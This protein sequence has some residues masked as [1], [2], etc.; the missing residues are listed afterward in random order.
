MWAFL[1]AL[2]HCH[3]VPIVVDKG[4]KQPLPTL[5]RKQSLKPPLPPLVRGGGIF[6]R[7]MTE[8]ELYFTYH[9]SQ[10]KKGENGKSVLPDF[11]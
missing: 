4:C 11:D 8:G 2:M 10:I 7:K 6:Q 5:A 1:D 9:H 3:M